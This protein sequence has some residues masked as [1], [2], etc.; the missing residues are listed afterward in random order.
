MSERKI[1]ENDKYVGF[2]GCEFS[3][4]YKCDFELKGIRFDS[5]EKAF[6]YC[7]A[8][9][10]NDKEIAEMILKSK[11]VKECKRLGRKVRNYDD[12]IWNENKEKYMRI[13]LFKK[14]S[15]DEKLK[16]MLLNTGNKI[17]VECAPFDKE[18]GIGIDVDDLMAGKKWKGKNKLGKV[19]MI[20]RELIREV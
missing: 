17:I 10:F 1:M 12:K 18:W 4:F 3:N 13:I 2:L 20:V 8:M 16:N 19:L 15:S 6:M 9:L 11:S 5:S 7:K 14:F